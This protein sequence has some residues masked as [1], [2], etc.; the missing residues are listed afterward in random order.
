MALVAVSE[1]FIATANAK[2]LNVLTPECV[3]DLSRALDRLNN[4]G[5]YFRF[6]TTDDYPTG[7]TRPPQGLFDGSFMRHIQGTARL[8]GTNV[9]VHSVNGRRGSHLVAVQMKSQPEFGDWNTNVR[10][11]GDKCASPKKDSVVSVEHLS[12]HFSHPGGIQSFGSIVAV[13][14]DINNNNKAGSEVRFYDYADPTSP[15]ERRDWRI[16]RTNVRAE[17]VAMS[18]IKRGVHAGKY[19]VAVGS[20]QLSHLTFYI[21]NDSDLNASGFRFQE[22][23]TWTERGNFDIPNYQGM[24]LISECS[25]QM[26]LVGTYKS[27]PLFGLPWGGKD[28]I[29][30]Y[31][32]E[33]SPYAGK[34]P[35]IAKFKNKHMTLKKSFFSAG[36]AVYVEPGTGELKAYATDYWPLNPFKRDTAFRFEEFAPK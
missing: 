10:C 9:L 33:L 1:D 25:G 27:K 23:A 24:Q 26:Y 31:K 12:S 29:D 30:T 19:V 32:I 6:R 18:Q 2:L 11:K 16:L 20:H 21:S 7:T 8:A 15:V 3:P 34:A 13:G 4:R 22:Q 35:Q 17:A 36:G 28:W 14:I 5:A